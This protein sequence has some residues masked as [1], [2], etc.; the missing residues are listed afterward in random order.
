[1]TIHLSLDGGHTAS[2]AVAAEALSRWWGR[3]DGPLNR[4][5]DALGGTLKVWR[6]PDGIAVQATVR[7]DEGQEAA[8][9]IRAGLEGA[10]PTQAQLEALPR[11]EP[12]SDHPLAVTLRRSYGDHPHGRRVGPLALREATAAS[13][14]AFRARCGGRG[15]VV[16]EGGGDITSAFEQFR[17][18]LGSNAK[19][20]GCTAG[21][22]EPADADLTVERSAQMG[23]GQ[24]WASLPAQLDGPEHAAA[25]MIAGELIS[26]ALEEDGREHLTGPIKASSSLYLPADGVSPRLSLHATYDAQQL[27]PLWRTLLSTRR[28]LATGVDAQS[29]TRAKSR[30]W[31]RWLTLE[32][33]PRAHARWVAGLIRRF[34]PEGPARWRVAVQSTT[35]DEA[36]AAAQALLWRN[37]QF[38]LHLPSS[39]GERVMA[40]GLLRGRLMKALEDAP[41]A[42]TVPVKSGD[43]FEI[44]PGLTGLHVALPDSPAMVVHLALGHGGPSNLPMATL[45]ASMLSCPTLDGEVSV[46]EAGV[47]WYTTIEPTALA[48]TLA[49]LDACLEAVDESTSV[50]RARRWAHTWLTASQHPGHKARRL[51]VSQLAPG[52]LTPE[53]IAQLSPGALRAQASALLRGPRLLVVGSTEAPESLAGIIESHLSPGAPV[54]AGAM[55]AKSPPTRPREA[56]TPQVEQHQAFAFPLPESRNPPWLYRALAAALVRPGGHLHTQ[57]RTLTGGSGLVSAEVVPTGGGGILVFSLSTPGHQ[58]ADAARLFWSSVERMITLGMERRPF[59]HIRRRLLGEQSIELATPS[60]RIGRIAAAL[61]RRGEGQAQSLLEED[62]RLLESLAP[63][64][65][66]NAARE[67]LRRGA[68]GEASVQMNPVQ[69]NPVQNNPVQKKGSAPGEE[70]T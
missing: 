31:R 43:P 59:E 9:A 14:S 40:D 60:G 28:T 12:T 66:Q 30:V 64:D 48:S 7:A 39:K 25:L 63:I 22:S 1:M 20:D 51:A 36:K 47:H 2:D 27:E 50:E 24:L 5:I 37:G 18:A 26:A 52:G 11:P 8:R 10:L 54:K 67:V 42:D 32:G 15:L 53:A 44:R 65:I 29:L 61:L 21:A 62:A 58:G 70:S 16:L 6:G 19:A 45:A 46:S 49:A 34:G 56:G 33:D 17:G 35:A 68:H 38:H 3:A 4:N 13:V 55:R 23:P 41:A 69:K 57:L